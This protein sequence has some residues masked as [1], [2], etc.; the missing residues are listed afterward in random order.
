MSGRWETLTAERRVLAVARTVTSLNRL[1][2]VLVVFADDDRIAV[3]FVV[4]AGSRFGAEVPGV[5][6]RI[7]ARIVTW[8][9]AVATDYDLILSASD[10]EDLHELGG[11]LVLLP[12]GAGFQKYS[13]HNEADVRERAGL[14]SGALWRDRKRVPELLV[15]AHDNQKSLVPGFADRVL[16][17][18]DPVMD[19]LIQL[20]SRRAELREQLGIGPSQSLVTLTSTWGPASLLGR[21]PK[22]PAQL[23][24]ELPYDEYRVAAVLHPNIWAAHSSWQI[25]QWLRT[26]VASGLILVP[27]TGPW[28]SVL[29][30]ASCVVG[31]H[32]SLSAYS[33]G[34]A[35]PLVLGAFG[36]EEVPRGTAM[37]RLGGSVPRLDGYESLADQ[38][39]ST[40]GK[41]EQQLLKSLAEDVFAR[42]GQALS[43][44]QRELFRVLEL[45]PVHRPQALEAQ[46]LGADPVDTA[47]FHVEI[48]DGPVLRVE[49]F[50]AD[51]AVFGRPRGVRHLVAYDDADV[52]LLQS[53]TA[54]VARIPPE[55]SWAAATLDRFPGCKVVVEPT[56]PNA[57]LLTVRE[58][59]EHTAYVAQFQGIELLA[60]ASVWLYCRVRGSET[61]RTAVLFANESGFVD[62]TLR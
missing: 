18:G 31:D 22:L 39:R 8:D 13:P 29:A 36:E 45:S 21:W 53:A 60:T 3:E 2:E 41:P 55:P 56:A 48:S 54:I 46:A 12:H 43:I 59:P 17:A 38:I 37:W 61:G 47:A 40:M 35:T 42:Q 10:H 26:A 15:V 30:A 20:S 28:Q 52:V 50:P 11:P 6:Q 23:L 33:S 44:L 25:H 24:A 5:L 62:F 49:R 9:T 14:R 27:P 34:L 16:V 58:S 51:L 19:N 4:S 7:G 57:A 32:G 1:L